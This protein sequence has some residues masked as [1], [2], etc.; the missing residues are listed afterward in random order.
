MR[1]KNYFLEAK[2]VGIVYHMVGIDQLITINKNGSIT[3][4][5]Y[6]DIST[7]RLKSVNWYYAGPPVI[8]GKFELDGDKIS[9]RY[10]VFP[11]QYTSLT[12]IAFSGERETIIKTDKLSL[13]YANRFI[14]I[15]ENIDKNLKYM[16]IKL[17]KKE[18]AKVRLPIYV[19]IKTRIM[20]DDDQIKAWGFK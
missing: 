19:Q 17:V 3:T 11:N 9:E 16:D 10:K 4:N 8:L 20:K 7:T 1:L 15:K 5:N 6:T 14:L 12:G 13:K 18:L 2:Q